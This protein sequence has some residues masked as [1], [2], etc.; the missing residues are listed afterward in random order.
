MVIR[1]W[2]GRRVPF[3][4]PFLP[5]KPII[6]AKKARRQR[7]VSPLQADKLMVF[8]LIISLTLDQESWA[9]TRSKLYRRDV[10]ILCAHS[11]K[12]SE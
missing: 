2:Q 10:C 9:L 11:S 5:A 6:E 1:V 4:V 7:S 12:P 3:V 8:G